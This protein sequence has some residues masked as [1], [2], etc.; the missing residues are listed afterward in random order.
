MK[1]TELKSFLEA[2]FT[3]LKENVR[4]EYFIPDIAYTT[5]IESLEFV[6]FKDD[7]VY[8]MT[9]RPEAIS[10]ISKKYTEFFIVMI[11]QMTDL[12]SDIH[13]SFITEKENSKKPEETKV[14]N[15]N[16]ENANLIAKYRFDTFV[17]GKSNEFAHSAAL[18]V[19]ESPG[20]AF[21]PLYLYSGSGLGKTHLMHSIGHYILDQN[22]R[23]K[24]LYVTSEA[25]MNEVIDTIR[26]QSN[27]RINEMRNKYRTVDVLM[28]DDIQYLLGRDRTQEE[29]FN[30]FNELHSAGKQIIISSDKPP[31]EL[32]SLEE[33]FRTRFEWGIIA[34]IHSPDFETRMAIL[35][36]NAERYGKKI[37]DSVFDF[38][39]S[40]ITT[41]IRE[42]EGAFN[43]LVAFSKLNKVE[44]SPD[45]LEDA[46]KDIINTDNSG[47]ITPKNIIGLVAEH[48]GITYEEIISNSRKKEL[49]IP[50]Q[51][52]MYLCRTLTDEPY[53]NIAQALNKKDHTTVI[54][55]YNKI[56]EDIKVNKNIANTIDIIKKKINPKI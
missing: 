42:L 54:H 41:N 38:I 1:S 29:F 26:S 2:N 24:V 10:Y 46:L 50:R 3:D 5:W 40:N 43:K 7:T 19:A 51:V 11:K 31:K 6:D 25:F 32:D 17:V 55:G 21:N 44:I 56:V 23:I 39:A 30:T 33:R 34:A 4:N 27:S 8:I 16:Y 53:Q 12:D 18:A 28:I 45:I 49:V 15:I 14:Y 47:E 36:M 52:C 13:I 22:P 48:Y 35:K 37:D 20:D 9:S